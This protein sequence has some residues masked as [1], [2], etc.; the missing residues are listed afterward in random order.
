MAF[1]NPFSFPTKIRHQIVIKLTSSSLK[2]LPEQQA[3]DM[4]T[5]NY[6]ISL[7]RLRFSLILDSESKWRGPALLVGLAPFTEIPRL[8]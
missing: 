5:T 3:T 4:K 8:S 1:L 6:L 2:L 7:F